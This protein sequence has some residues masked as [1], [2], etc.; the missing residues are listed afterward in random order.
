[1]HRSLPIRLLLV[2]TLLLSQ[3]GG[4]THSIAHTLEQR[5]QDQSQPHDRIC[6]LCASYAQL[7]STLGSHTHQFIPARQDT[8]F[9]TAASASFR[10]AAFTAFAARAPPYS[11]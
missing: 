6:D 7:G 2:F 8:H 5:S 11:I 3:L 4:L 1:M 10:S 9:V